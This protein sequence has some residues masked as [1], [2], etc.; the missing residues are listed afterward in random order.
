[1]PGQD[2]INPGVQAAILPHDSASH[3]EL[4][5]FYRGLAAVSQ[6]TTVVI[7]SPNHYD[8]GRVNI[9][10]TTRAFQTIDGLLYSDTPIINQLRR[11]GL[12]FPNVHV[13]ANMYSYDERGFVTGYRG[14]VVHSYNKSEVQL[15]GT[16]Y[17]SLVSSRPNVLLLGDGVGDLGMTAGFSHD[18]CLSVGFLNGVVNRREE[19][20]Q[21]FDLVVEDDGDLSAVLSLLRL[22]SAGAC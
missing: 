21:H 15:R 9:Q 10:A 19:F 8:S 22:V 5:K 3:K 14:S 1:M 6:P 13:V 4:T 20:L 16:P 2:A 7:L 12:L 17:A 18:V 11:N